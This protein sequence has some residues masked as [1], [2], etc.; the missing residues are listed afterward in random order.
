MEKKKFKILL[1]NLGYC[2]GINGFF[3]QYIAKMHRY[4]YLPR[5]VEKTILQK[6]KDVIAKENPDV[7]CLVEIKK[8][9]QV[10]T[11]VSEDYLFHAANTKYGEKSLLKKMP[12]FYNKGNA[13]IAKE[14][15]SFKV[16]YMKHGT[17]SLAYEI[18]L[19]NNISLLLVHFSLTKSVRKKQ[20]QCIT[21]LPLT[22][23]QF[24][25]CGDFNVFG[26]LR[27]LDHMVE[28]SNLQI[29]NPTPTFPAFKPSK[30]LDLFLCSRDIPASARVLD[31]QISDHLPV[32][33]EIPV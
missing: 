2:T 1:I 17:K 25:V 16:H 10:R 20:F 26:G 11:L 32:V 9:R 23:K 28:N 18:I 29:I 27:E 13:F 3:W 22:H 4:V 12:F 6:L 24:I 33:L 5:T 31:D 14:D 7:I 19:P 8:G 21:Q 15:L 30:S